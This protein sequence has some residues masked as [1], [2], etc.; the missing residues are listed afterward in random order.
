MDSTP[1]GPA[2]AFLPRRRVF[3]RIMVLRIRLFILLLIAVRPACACWEDAAARYNIDPALL[4][5]IAVVES[6][7][8]PRAVSPRNAN[9][10]YDVGVLQINTGH[11]PAL[12][13]FGISEGR[14]F[15]P[16]T[17]MHVGAW[18]LA[19]NIARYGMTW[20]AVGAYNVGCRNL[21]RAEC[22]ERRN[23]YAWRVY[24]AYQAYVRR[25]TTKRAG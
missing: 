24:R 8:N 22:T 17:N 9:G 12:A 18:V 14:L 2:A 7:N 20:D 13:Q 4:Y 15:D 1:D 21:S 6:D 5:A 19:D 10:T 16:C 3:L 11:L 23:R 25:V